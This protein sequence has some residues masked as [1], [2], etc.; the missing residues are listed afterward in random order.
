MCSEIV[1]PQ[2]YLLLNLQPNLNDQMTKSS[3]ARL[4]PK[5]ISAM[6][7]WGCVR[8]NVLQSHP[9]E[10]TFPFNA[11]WACHNTWESREETF[12]DEFP[13]QNSAV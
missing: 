1:N 10:R 4:S 11:V 6:K 3:H 2:K 5:S 9:C 7:H 13:T 8:W 12:Q